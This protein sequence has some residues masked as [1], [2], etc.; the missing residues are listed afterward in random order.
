MKKDETRLGESRVV[1]TGGGPFRASLA[2]ASE[3]NQGAWESGLVI[4][5]VGREV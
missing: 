1:A 3:Y 5:G 4:R 2:G